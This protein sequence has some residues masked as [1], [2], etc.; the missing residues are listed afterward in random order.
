[1]RIC[2]DYTAALSR[3]VNGLVQA[4]LKIQPFDSDNDLAVTAADL[5][6]RNAWL[7]LPEQE[8][9]RF[10][11]DFLGIG[12]AVCRTRLELSP[13]GDGFVPVLQVFNPEHLRWNNQ[14]QGWSYRAQA[15]T[16]GPD[17]SQVLQFEELAISSNG[18]DQHGQRWHIC[19]DWK[20]GSNAGVVPVLAM[21]WQQNAVNQR[22]WIDYLDNLGFPPTKAIVPSEDTESPEGQA[23]VEKFADELFASRNSDRIVVCPKD[24]EG[25]GFDVEWKAPVAGVD[26]SSYLQAYDAYKSRVARVLLGATGAANELGSTGS[27]AAAETHAGIETTLVKGDI[28]LVGTLLRPVICEEFLAVNHYPGPAPY[29]VWSIQQ[30][31]DP[32]V[33]ANALTAACDALEKLRALGAMNLRDIATEFGIELPAGP[34]QPV[35]DR[36]APPTPP[37]PPAKPTS[38]EEMN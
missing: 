19:T 35:V 25:Y 20:P 31:P 30:K 14:A 24:R 28:V 21:S 34:V 29:I 23:K 33:R 17:G 22:S 26:A 2:A 12:V 32:K 13:S 36:A 37:S 10:L 3:R 27:Y 15:V 38:P 5:I 6:L 16:T 4:D 9:K 11:T 7:A 1:M 8:L 18:L